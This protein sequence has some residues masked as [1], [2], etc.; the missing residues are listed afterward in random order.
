MPTL[1]T[2]SLVASVRRGGFPSGEITCNMDNFGGWF[3]MKSGIGTWY[4]KV[5]ST[6]RLFQGSMALRRL[7]K[8]SPCV[9]FIR[10]LEEPRYESKLSCFGIRSRTLF[11]NRV[12]FLKRSPLDY[13]EY[14]SSEARPNPIPHSTFQLWILLLWKAHNIG[15]KTKTICY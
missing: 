1:S 2:T 3:Q 6:E 15:M 7:W 11:W 5:V 13:Q 9:M 8:Y 12:T 10:Q 4:T 14:T